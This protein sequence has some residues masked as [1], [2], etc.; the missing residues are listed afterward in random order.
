MSKQEVEMVY[1]QSRAS[2][3]TISFEIVLIYIASGL[4]ILT[5]F[6][7]IKVLLYSSLGYIALFMF[8]TVVFAMIGYTIYN[9]AKG[10][11]VLLSR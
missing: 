6:N 5:F 7:E 2:R 3:F 8:L 1:E 4:I 10:F 9:F 11:K